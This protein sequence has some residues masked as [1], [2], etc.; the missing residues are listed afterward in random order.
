MGQY[1]ELKEGDRPRERLR[2]KNPD[3]LRE[4]EGGIR[5][6]EQG[7]RPQLLLLVTPG[8]MYNLDGSLSLSPPLPLPLP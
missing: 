3:G 7:T 5:N 6:W 1:V 4:A 2:K 8:E